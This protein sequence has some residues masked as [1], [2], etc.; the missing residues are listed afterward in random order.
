MDHFKA[1]ANME[2]HIEAIWNGEYEVP[3]NMPSP[4][5][6]DLGA[7]CGAFAVWAL[8]R[9]PEAELHCY[10]PSPD[11]FKFLQANLLEEE[12][13]L[14]VTLYRHAIGDSYHQKLFRGKNNCGEASFFQLGEQAQDF[15]LVETKSALTLPKDV[16]ILKI[17]TEGCEVEILVPL[18]ADGRQFKAIMCEYHKDIAADALILL[19]IDQ[20][21]VF[22]F[23][24]YG[25]DRG[26]LKFLRRT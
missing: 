11:N 10:E 9:W 26:M 4:R 23:R 14:Q 22:E 8:T 15:D 7:N 5:I 25:K 13:K 20:Y 12:A 24:K 3:L 16:D 1:P 18:I 6:C 19:L 17:D 21:L 2:S